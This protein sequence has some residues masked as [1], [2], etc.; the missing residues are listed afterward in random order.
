MD[1]LRSTLGQ[2]IVEAA[3]LALVM[4]LRHEQDE[5]RLRQH[6]ATGGAGPRFSKER[7]LDATN[8]RF[9]RLSFIAEE[10]AE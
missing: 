1:Y 7:E 8:G 3:R 6:E 10:G 2:R 5:Q 9:A 4:H